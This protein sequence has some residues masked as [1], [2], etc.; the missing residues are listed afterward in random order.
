[1]KNT[2]MAWTLAALIGTVQAGTIQ[3][4]VTDRDG[5]P[6][7]DV[8]VLVEVAG[9]AAAQ[10]AAAPVTI[11]QEDL[12]F[13]PFLTVVPVGTTLRF[14]NRDSYDH[15]VRSTPS[16]PLGNTPSVKN[17]ELR[18]DG[19]QAAAAPGGND[20]YKAAPAPRKRSGSSTADVKVDQPG[21]IG[22][23]CR[24]RQHRGI[25]I[26]KRARGHGVA[27]RRTLRRGLIR[28]RRRH[29]RSV[30]HRRGRS[31]RGGIQKFEVPASGY[32]NRRRDTAAA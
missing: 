30:R 5:K 32:R 23:G 17:I 28:D 18:L 11:V 4:A 13:V 31:E 9:K 10:P 19:S 1:M 3:L 15:H 12:R 21:A 22:L 29:E 25:R 2:L 24:I 27:E 7:P 14:V 20:E 8:V 16:G 26:G 6:V